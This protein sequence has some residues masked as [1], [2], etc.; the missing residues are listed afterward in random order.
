MSQNEN[1]AAERRLVPA[2]VFAPL[3]G[4]NEARAYDLARRRLVKCVRLGRQ[5]RFVLPDALDDLVASG[6]FAPRERG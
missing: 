1:S 2:R 6:G 5:V 3:A 4:I